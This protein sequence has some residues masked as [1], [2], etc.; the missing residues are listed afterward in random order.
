MCEFIFVLFVLVCD[1]DF[2]WCVYLVD[3]LVVDGF[4]VIMVV[5]IEDVCDK[6]VFCG[7]CVFVFGLFVVV[8]DVMVLLCE[9]RAE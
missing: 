8:V 4:V 7:L 9:L 6:F 5:T 2:E 3:N 1:L